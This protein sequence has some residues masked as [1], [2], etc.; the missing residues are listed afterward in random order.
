MDDTTN[1][2]LTDY[3]Q[4]VQ[5]PYPETAPEILALWA[6]QKEI[7]TLESEL[8]A[9]KKH[10]ADALK[11]LA[12]YADK[13]FRV[14]DVKVVRALDMDL[15]RQNHPDAWDASKPGDK[16]L[17]SQLRA[18]FGDDKLLDLVRSMDPEKYDAERTLTL[19]EFDKIAGD[20]SA[21]KRHVGT[22]YHLIAKPSSTSRIEYIGQSAMQSAIQQSKRA[23]K[24]DYPADYWDGVDA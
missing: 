2:N 7:E 1:P 17:L 13:N 19:T 14:T 24:L 20:S 15:I 10:F 21:K 3:L 23:K 9:R 11:T 4:T 12:S 6:E 5:N 22:A 16:Y 8:T 18:Y